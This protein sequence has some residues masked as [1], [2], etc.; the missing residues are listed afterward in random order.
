MLKTHSASTK[1]IIVTGGV[2]SGLGK[3]VMTA[4]LGLLLKLR[5]YKVSAVKFDGYLN[6]DAGTMNPY[7]HGEVFVLEDGLECDM[8][9]GTYE[10]FLDINLNYFNNPTGGKIFQKVLDKERKGEYL[11]VDVQM[12][13]HIT[14]EI[15]DWVKKVGKESKADII[16]VEVGGTVGDIENSYFLE[17]MRELRMELG[18]ENVVFVHLTLVPIL[19]AVGEHKTKPTQHSVQKLREIGISRTRLFA[20]PPSISQRMQGVR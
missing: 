17:A 6:V 11:G 18:A 4:S 8:D 19:A 7:R 16:L 12:I 20:G 13:P 1:Y 15:R 9:L 10:R 3:G 14:G 2:M 5:G